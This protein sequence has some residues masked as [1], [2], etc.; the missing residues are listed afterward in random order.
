MNIY[1]EVARNAR[2]AKARAMSAF[3]APFA[4]SRFNLFDSGL[5]AVKHTGVTV[6]DY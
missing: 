5:N 6:W 1:R 4:P 3:L 2:K